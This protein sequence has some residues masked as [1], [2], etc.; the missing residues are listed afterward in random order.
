MNYNI[1]LTQSSSF[2]WRLEIYCEITGEPMNL[3]G[4]SIHF[5]LRSLKGELMANLTQYTSVN[6][7]EHHAID[8]DAPAIALIGLREAVCRYDVAIVLP[9]NDVYRPL[10]GT[11]YIKNAVSEVAP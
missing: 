6:A 5:E 9:N 3:H 1:E 8:V 7:L 11:A 2:K 4:S 10:R